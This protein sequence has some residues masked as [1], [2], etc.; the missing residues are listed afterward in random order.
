M[1]IY[2]DLQRTT[3]IQYYPFNSSTDISYPIRQRV[4][5]VTPGLCFASYKCLAVWRQLPRITDNE[6][7]LIRGMAPHCSEKRTIIPLLTGRSCRGRRRDQ[8]NSSLTVYGRKS[9]K[10]GETSQWQ[11]T[12]VNCRNLLLVAH[13]L[14]LIDPYHPNNSEILIRFVVR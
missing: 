11:Q 12:V 3:A 10:V 2:W 14:L 8:T 13:F 9:V 6:N 7:T 4:K 5:C 1:L